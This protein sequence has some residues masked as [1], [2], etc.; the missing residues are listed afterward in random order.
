MTDMPLISI[1]IIYLSQILRYIV[2]L[3]FDN[4]RSV[5]LIVLVKITMIF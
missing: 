2:Y 3:G 1:F 5:G 4:I